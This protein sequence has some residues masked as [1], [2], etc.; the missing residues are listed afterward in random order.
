MAKT[1]RKLQELKCHMDLGY[2]W[3]SVKEACSRE[4]P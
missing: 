1:Q 4:N 2:K 3:S